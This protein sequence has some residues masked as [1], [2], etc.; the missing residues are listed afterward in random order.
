MYIKLTCTTFD[1]TLGSI[2]SGKRSMLKRDNDTKALFAS[3]PSVSFTN[4]KQPNDIS[5]TYE[6]SPVNLF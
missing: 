5:D 6:T 4:T 3:S 1:I 2:D